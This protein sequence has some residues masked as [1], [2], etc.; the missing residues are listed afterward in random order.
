MIDFTF[1]Q[2]GEKLEH[3]KLDHRFWLNDY[4]I[5][6]M[7]MQQPY[8]SFFRQD[9][10]KQI[11]N[12]QF[13]KTT[14]W[15]YKSIFWLYILGFVVPFIV[16]TVLSGWHDKDDIDHRVVISF[17]MIPAQFL[18]TIVELIGIVYMG[19]NYFKHSDNIVNLSQ[20]L[21]FY[22]NAY[23][24]IFVVEDTSGYGN[25]PQKKFV[26][27]ILIVL[28]V[29]KVINLLRV[30]EGISFNIKL[31]AY[32]IYDLG[33]FL[34]CYLAFNLFFSLC[35][36]SLGSEPDG[37]LDSARELGYFGR[38]SLSVWR[39][40]VGKLSFAIYP[41]IWETEQPG[42]MKKLHIFLIY[43]VYAI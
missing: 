23:L 8:D 21:L 11:I 12:F 18:L 34:S 4:Y 43:M 37:E 16:S 22:Y 38:I 14:C 31:I 13:E 40:S 17:V 9:S 25:V 36:V 3:L 7:I 33:P 35:Y 27:I 39:N 29:L 6:R 20:I 32:C 41:T 28:S 19:K 2:I 42:I 24:M 30:F 1:L 26:T 10:V 5:A 15:V